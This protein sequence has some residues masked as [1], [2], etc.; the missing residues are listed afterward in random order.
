MRILDFSGEVPK[1]KPQ[2]L[3][4]NQAQYAENVDLYGGLLRPIREPQFQQYLVDE[5]G[6]AYSRDDAAMFVMV[7]DKAVGFKDNVHWV[8]DPRNSAGTGTILFVRD[9]QLYRLSPRMIEAGTGA[10]P[11]GIE[12]PQ[13]APSLSIAAGRGCLTK[14]DNRCGVSVKDCTPDTPELRAYKITYVNEC[15]EESAPSPASE[16]IEVVNGDGVYITDTS[17]PPAN[18]IERRYYRTATTTEGEVVWLFVGAYP[19]SAER[20]LDSVCPDELGEALS[21]DDHYPPDCIEGITVTRNLQTI[22]W[23]SDTFWVSEPKLPHAYKPATRV[24]LPY[25]IKFIAGYTPTVEGNTHYDNIAVTEGHP[26]A[27]GVR[28]DAQTTVQELA[29]WY[30]PLTS[31]SHTVHNGMVLYVAR[32]GIVAIAG[33]KVSLIT[34]HFVTEREWAA[35]NPSTM[36]LS[37][38]D[39]RVFAW[40][41][42]TEDNQYRGLLLVFPITDERRA[43]S[44][45]RLSLAV[46][47]AAVHTGQGLVLLIGRGLYVWNKGAKYLQY[48]WVSKREVSAAMWFPAVVKAVGDTLQE[49]RRGIRTLEESFADWCKANCTLDPLLFFDKHPEHRKH[50][51]YLL[52]TANDLTI[53][54]FGDGEGLYTRRIRYSTPVML[55]ARKRCIEWS[56]KLV[57]TTPLREVHLQ[58]SRNDLQNDGGHA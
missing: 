33:T 50:M 39:Q 32:A 27:L 26:Y 20:Y 42:S 28:D 38:Y 1:L 40:Y 34:E 29:A 41:K 21:T 30:P 18:A 3:S 37:S 22:V 11:V 36:R 10:T 47:Y 23:A 45:S 54:I 16:P 2:A 35:F 8:Y 52:G 57:G 12:P 46:R 51:S 49:Q 25:K 6:N 14:W 43:A 19:I 5:Y 4:L 31:F 7:G 56:I 44:F 17:T 48:T 15:G 58:K 24:V 55:K 9:G 53:T 13:Q